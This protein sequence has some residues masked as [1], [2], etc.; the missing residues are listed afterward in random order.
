MNKTKLLII[1]V[2][3]GA[4]ALAAASTDIASFRTWKNWDALLTYDWKLA[5]FRWF[6]G[7]VLGGL[8]AAGV[9]TQ[10]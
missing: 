3:A 5:S 8:A 9:A 2:A 10:L 4:G 1:A 6:Q 7:A